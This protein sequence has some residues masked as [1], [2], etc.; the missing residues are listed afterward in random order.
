MI[1]AL[2]EYSFLQNAVIAALFSSVIC[3]I[4]GDVI[5]EK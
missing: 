3:G 5:V 4:I 1:K 2:L